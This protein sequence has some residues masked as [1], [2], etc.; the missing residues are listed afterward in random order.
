M[1]VSGRLRGKATFNGLVNREQ[2]IKEG[3]GAIC[4]AQPVSGHARRADFL[5]IHVQAH[6]PAHRSD[7]VMLGTQNSSMRGTDFVATSWPCAERCVA[8]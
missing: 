1:A 2:W 4:A 8:H 6:A 3:N 7:I 5:P